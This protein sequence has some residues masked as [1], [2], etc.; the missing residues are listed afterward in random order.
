MFFNCRALE[1]IKIPSPVTEIGKDMF[2]GCVAL[3]SITMPPSNNVFRH[4]KA[5]DHLKLSEGSNA[6]VEALLVELDEE[7][8]HN[9]A[10]SK[11]KINKKKKRKERLQAAKDKDK[12]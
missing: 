7:K 3:K 4:C 1:T 11:A 10:S 12:G 6:A 8:I 5:L 9:E 2:E